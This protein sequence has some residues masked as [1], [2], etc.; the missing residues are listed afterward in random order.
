MTPY[1]QIK[2]LESLPHTSYHQMCLEAGHAALYFRRVKDALK[3]EKNAVN[4]RG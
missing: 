1:E 4:N 3:E 2:K